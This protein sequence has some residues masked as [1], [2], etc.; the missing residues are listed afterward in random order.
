MLLNEDEKERM[1]T[2]TYENFNKNPLSQKR[3][4]SENLF[5][6]DAIKYFTRYSD[7]VNINI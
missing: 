1:K 2:R 3:Q 6:P 7:M 5:D 4:M